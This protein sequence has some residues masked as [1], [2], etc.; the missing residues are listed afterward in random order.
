M[1]RVLALEGLVHELRVA[2][3]L[4]VKDIL[5]VLLE[6]PMILHGLVVVN[7]VRLALWLDLGGRHDGGEYNLWGGGGCSL[8]VERYRV[9][10][11]ND[12]RIR[13]GQA[14]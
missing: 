4:V 7:P 5:V 10:K 1:L 13:L 3:D 2:Q 11:P 6:I 12:K 14:K 9:T 8:A